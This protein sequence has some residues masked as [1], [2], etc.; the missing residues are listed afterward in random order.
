MFQSNNKPYEVKKK[1]KLN[2]IKLIITII[3]IIRNIYS[4][5]TRGK[6]KNINPIKSDVK[7]VPT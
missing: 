6:N 1:K 5:Y 7:Y 2:I 3:R 4:E